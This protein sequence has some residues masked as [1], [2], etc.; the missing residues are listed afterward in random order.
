MLS[1]HDWSLPHRQLS[2]ETAGTAQTFPQLFPGETCCYHCSA[3]S[4]R[5]RPS[6]LP[7]TPS[8]CKFTRVSWP[9][10][11]RTA[12]AGP[13]MF[14]QL[15]PPCEV[16]AWAPGAE[17]L[18]ATRGFLWSQP[19]GSSASCK[20]KNLSFFN[21]RRAFIVSC[22]CVMFLNNVMTWKWNKIKL[23]LILKCFKSR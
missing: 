1:L 8:L 10:W 6:S 23:N 17:V 16:T 19:K 12:W 22:V 13:T 14:W 2:R 5:H 18:R 20:D 21:H 7:H 4:K 15:H 3:S 9:F 11:A